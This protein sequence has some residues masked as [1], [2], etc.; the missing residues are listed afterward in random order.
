MDKQLKEHGKG[1]ATRLEILNV[2][3]GLLLQR[4]FTAVGLKEILDTCGVPKGSFYYYFASKEAFCC[5]VL[6][7]YVEDYVTRLNH[8]LTEGGDSG[9][10]RLM[11]YWSAWIEDPATGTGMAEECLLVKL[12]AEVA[13]LSEDM[14]L[15][16]DRGCERLVARLSEVMTQGMDDGSIPRTGPPEDLSHTLYQL[17]LG[18]ALLARL[19]RDKAPLHHALATTARMLST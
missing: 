16:M 8:F 18:A 10:A 1:E 4:G 7:Q 14:R 9:R 13:D 19:K 17:W 11:A 2:G 6:E 15:V 3:R 12:A 5:A